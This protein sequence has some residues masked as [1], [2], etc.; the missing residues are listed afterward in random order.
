MESSPEDQ[1]LLER[2]FKENA[3]GW[4]SPFFHNSKLRLYRI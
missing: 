1:T 2:D 3:G 4:F